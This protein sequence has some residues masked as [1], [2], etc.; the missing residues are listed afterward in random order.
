MDDA[1]FDIVVDYLRP[2]IKPAYLYKE[3]KELQEAAL[4]AQDMQPRR[5][6]TQ[7]T[8]MPPPLDDDYK[9]DDSNTYQ[10]Y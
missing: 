1:A 9:E 2:K 7:G 10:P 8:P 4:R 5:P 6:V 3:Q